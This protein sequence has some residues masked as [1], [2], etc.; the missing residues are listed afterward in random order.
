MT[1]QELD[2]WT[3]DF[4]IFHA[5]FADV[6]ARSEPREQAAKYMRGLISQVDRKNGWQLA[7]AMGDTTP[8]STQRLLY[9]ANWEADAARDE[10]QQFIIETFGHPDGIGVV[11]ETSFLKQG[12][13]S[14]GVARQYSGTA[15]KVANC[16]V[17]TFLSYATPNGKVFLDRRLYLPKAWCEDAERCATAKVPKSVRFQTKPKQ[18]AEMLQHAWA[19]GIPMRWVT[20][21]EVY[22][23][24]TDLRDTVEASGRWYVMAVSSHTPVWEQRPAV[25]IPHRKPP[26][27]RRQGRPREKPQ[28]AADA[29]CATTVSLLVVSWPESRWQRLTVAEG[30]KGPRIYD[31]GCQRVVE[32]RDGLPKRAAWL[33]V[34]R[35]VADPTDIA[36]YLSNAAAEVS[37]LRLAEVASTRY[38]VEQCIEQAKGETG[39]DEYE[40]RHWH[41]W[42][43]HITLSMMAQAWLASIRYKAQDRET[44]SPWLAQLTVPE[45]RRLLDIALP[46]PQ[47]SPQLRLAWSDFRRAKRKQARRSH[48]RT[49]HSQTMQLIHQHL[50][51]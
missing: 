12:A 46:L 25:V 28:L 44:L 34:R 4:E 16:Q 19:Q 3:E 43:R 27:Q 37:L 17:G 24:A 33:L 9:Q 6:F 47:R 48:Y 23:N 40:V 51:P 26:G 36:Y 14:V 32:S 8:D 20:G 18:A 39:L 5:R 30:E 22:G 41:S 38:T 11:D 1:R 7:E 21:D 10:L 31:W 29:P 45:V 15:G 2:S 13:H 49:K 50:P 42:H 35:S